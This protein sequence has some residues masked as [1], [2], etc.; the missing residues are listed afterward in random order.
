MHA[1]FRMDEMHSSEDTRTQHRPNL[2]FGEGS[3]LFDAGVH[4]SL[5]RVVNVLED[6]DDLVEGGTERV[7]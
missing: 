7:L 1:A 3:L 4:F 5:K 2:L 6:E